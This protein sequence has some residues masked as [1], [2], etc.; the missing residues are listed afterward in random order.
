MAMERFI[1]AIQRPRL[2]AHRL[3][4]AICDPPHSRDIRAIGT[5][6]SFQF[7]SDAFILKR[8]AH[9]RRVLPP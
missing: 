1:D 7:G 8:F 5:M 6:R 4:G 9:H 2:R 3:L